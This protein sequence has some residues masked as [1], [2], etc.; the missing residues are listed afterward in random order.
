M[1]TASHELVRSISVLFGSEHTV[2]TH[3]FLTGLQAQILKKA[4]RDKIKQ[5]HPDRAVLTGKT[6]EEMNAEACRINEAYQTLL[7]HLTERK[8]EGDFIRQSFFYQAPMPQKIVRFAEFLYY[9]GLIDWNTLIS[10]IVWQYQARPKIGEI[11]LQLELLDKESFLYIIRNKGFQEKFGQAAVRLQIIHQKDLDRVLY[12]QKLYNKPIG[13]YFVE[14][15]ILEQKQLYQ[16]LV[17]NAAHN[18]KY[19]K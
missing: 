2:N 9:K 19:S 3:L 6:P 18:W 7:K 12:Q 8:T 11:A 1:E 5:S 14:K 15:G 10:S 4:F 17:E 13:L 16:L